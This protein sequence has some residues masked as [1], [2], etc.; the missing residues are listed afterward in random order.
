MNNTPGTMVG[1]AGHDQMLS[2]KVGP[3]GLCTQ[4][5]VAFANV[6]GHC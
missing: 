1:P 6:A 3:G 5:I 2:V 4:H